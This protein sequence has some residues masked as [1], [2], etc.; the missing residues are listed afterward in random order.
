[1]SSIVNFAKKVRNKGLYGSCT[2]IGNKALNTPYNALISIRLRR[3]LHTYGIRLSENGNIN[4]IRE[5]TLNYI[6]SMRIKESP[7][8]QYKYSQTQTEPVL[9]AAI[10]AALTRHLY[11]DLDE[12]SGKQREEWIDYI[13]S[14]QTD[15]GLF[16]DKLIENEIASTADWWGW[17]HLTLH[18][19]MALTA[20]DA[21]AEKKFK[22]LEPF[23]DQK[24][25]VEWLESRNWGNDPAGVSNEI[26]NYATLLQY[27]RDFQSEEWA[28]D[29]VK[30]ILN[31]LDETQ[32]PETGLWGN[33]FDTPYFLSIGV[34][35]G[36]H[37][38]LL[39]FYDK[40]PIKYT[41]KIVDSVLATQNTLGGFGVTPNSSACEDI[42]SVDPLVRLYFYPEYRREII[43]G[44]LEKAL[45]WILTNMNEDGGFVFRRLDSFK[46]GHEKM[47]SKAEES[48]MFPMWFRTLTLAY[49]AKVLPD[50]MV[51]KFNWEILE[52]PG[53][54]F[55]R[56]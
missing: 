13:Q 40:R 56:T 34:Q 5:S 8:G 37:L 26:Q 24:F 4:E 41:D 10:Y 1:M 9:Y 46:Y 49:I 25:V 33:R 42:D 54:Q 11:R 3:K 23:K 30:W 31:W 52:C 39:Y 6:E 16:K 29:A 28:G 35:T 2:V 55:W 38:W 48:A 14:H 51:G 36:Y 17:R 19:I 21:N 50:S 53:L 15:D 20:L 43:K 7:Y 45:P 12:L 27:A 44:A 18:A 47:Y 32:D 22:F